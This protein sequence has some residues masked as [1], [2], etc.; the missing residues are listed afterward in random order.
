[1]DCRVNIAQVV[2][3]VLDAGN[4]LSVFQKPLHLFP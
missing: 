2:D 3:V 4:L 1:M